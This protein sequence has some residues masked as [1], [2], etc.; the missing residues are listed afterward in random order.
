MRSS[1][2]GNS[3]LDSR[4]SQ[5]LKNVQGML[6]GRSIPGKVLLTRRS[7]AE[8]ASLQEHSPTFHRSFSENDAGTS[9][10][11]DTSK[12]QDDV[13]TAKKPNSSSIANKLKP[14]PPSI[15]VSSGEVQKSSVGARATDSAR[16]MKF[17]KEL[18]GATVML[19]KLRELAWSGVP[20]YMRPEVWRLLLG[21]APSNSDRREVVLRRKRLEYFECVAQF[22][23]IPDSERSDDEVN[24]LRQISVDCP[25]TVPDVTFFQQPQVQKSLER[26]LYTWA[27]R[28]PA[29]GYVQ[30]I[31]DLATPFLIVFLSEHLEGDIDSWS[32]S[33]L[34]LE[35]IFDVE[36]DCYWCLSKLLDGMQDHYTFAQP[37]IQRLV[38]R[39]KELVRRIDESISVHMEE[40]GLEFLQFAFR[41]FNCLL[42][43][44]IPFNL[45]TRLWDTYLA[46]GDAL[47]D[48]LIYIFASF[49]LTWSDKLQKLDFQELV[50]FLQHLP[51]N[52]WTDQ[53]LEMVL[54]R[55]YMWHSMFNNSPSHLA[56]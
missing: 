27:I 29:S 21:Y 24:M 22:Y 56:S 18:S 23:D 20:P 35:K 12:E 8:E 2:D 7:P 54:S 43:R 45:V 51:T 39:L 17:T 32:I 25:R 53:E 34:P 37:G 42:I 31:N 11:T 6:K 47:P 41:W 16:V 19:D 55:A 3:N 26:I 14:S 4:F 5:T 33:D 10:R 28:H 38:F 44:E 46:E 52:N 49:L 40:Q 30:G 50:M 36:A 1:N 13:W 48:F 9:N 15:E